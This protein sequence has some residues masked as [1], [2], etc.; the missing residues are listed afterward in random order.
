ML[1]G[2]LP[3]PGRPGDLDYSWVRAY[4]AGSRFGWGLLD[5]FLLSIITLIF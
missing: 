4:C 3:M 1:L 5:F 2:K